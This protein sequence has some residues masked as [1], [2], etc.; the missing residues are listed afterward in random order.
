MK[1]NKCSRAMKNNSIYLILI[2]LLPMLAI[3]ASAVPNSLTLQG[4]LTNLAGASQQGTFNFTFRIYDAA[5]DGSQLWASINQSVA[6]D[7]NGVYDA[8]LHNINMSFAEQYYLG[9]AVQGDNESTPRINLTSSPYS[10][11]ANV[12]E[13]LNKN[14]AYS[15]FNLSVAQNLS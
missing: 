3:P 6:T 15:V 11:R 14:K 1:K 9:I 7:A 12:S 10:F 4:K 13:D 2:A 8:V 5:A